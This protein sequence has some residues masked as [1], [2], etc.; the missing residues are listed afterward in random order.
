MGSSA[1]KEGSAG[2]NLEAAKPAGCTWMWMG[3]HSLNE[4]V[5][6]V[7]GLLPAGEPLHP[8]PCSSLAATEPYNWQQAMGLTASLE[9]AVQ[10]WEALQV[11]G[12]PQP[13]APAG[14]ACCSA[15][16]DHSPLPQAGSTSV[17]APRGGGAAAA[18]PSGSALWPPLA[19]MPGIAAEHGD[20]C[21][22]S[23]GTLPADVLR[24]IFT[25]LASTEQAATAAGS[26]HWL[27]LRQAAR[28][29]ASCSPNAHW[30]TVAQSEVRDT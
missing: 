26:P 21:P 12:E 4:E 14:V 24:Q 19:R 27:S 5:M 11:S 28:L 3:Q 22:T 8:A 18:R 10:E 20:C 23:W 1:R 30:R 2:T 29:M 6:P 13:A 15:A 25:T 9:A 16:L 17:M 7:W